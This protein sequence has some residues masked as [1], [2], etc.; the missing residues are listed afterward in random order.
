MDGSNVTAPVTILIYKGGV[1]PSKGT[2]L[3]KQTLNQI[4]PYQSA[5]PAQNAAPIKVNIV[6]ETDAR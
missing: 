4:D 2:L 5:M 6:G 1:D 3:L